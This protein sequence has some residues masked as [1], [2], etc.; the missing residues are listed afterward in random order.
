MG[1]GI[2]LDVDV[3]EV[4]EDSADCKGLFF[5]CKVSS[6]LSSHKSI[7]TRKAL[8]LLKRRSCSGCPSCYYLWDY[9]REDVSIMEKQDFI[10]RLDNG[11]VYEYVVTSSQDYWGEWDTEGDFVEVD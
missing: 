8:R 2:T 11:Q 4:E 9:L 5:R 3:N 6:F 1:L 7:E 10:D